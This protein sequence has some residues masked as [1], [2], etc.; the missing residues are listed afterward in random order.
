MKVHRK[1]AF[2]QA[3]VLSAA[4]ILPLCGCKSG[5]RPFLQVQFCVANAQGVALFKKTLQAIA[6]EE[7]MRY[8]DGIEATTQDLKI[9]RPAAKNMHTSGGLVYV[10]VEAEGFGLEGGNLGLNPYDISVGFGPDTAE[11]RAFSSIVVA[12]LKQYWT[13]KVVPKNSGAFPNPECSQGN[14][15]AT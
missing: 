9:L 3:L 13:L 10:G 7:H 2:Y 4:S 15:G 1:R 14:G 12:R 5:Q 6:R 11:A 8:I